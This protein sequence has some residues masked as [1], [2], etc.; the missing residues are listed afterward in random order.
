MTG[1]QAVLKQEA[2]EALVV[3]PNGVFV[4]CTYGRGGHSKM[5]LDRLTPDG[6]LMVIDKDIEAIEHA[7]SKFARDDR[8][9]INHGSF[10]NIG[11]YAD[12]H[13]LG[14]FDGVLIDLGV[15][16]PQ[17]DQ[18]ARGFS[19]DRDGPL[20]MRMDQS[21]GQTTS[22]WLASAESDSRGIPVLF[23]AVTRG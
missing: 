17:L 12:D 20:D 3:N 16:S 1:H 9:F 5:I 6:R 11:Q 4:D 7:T 8:V 10:K 18:A 13:G 19:F 23:P 22:E 21:S 15:S 14:S 2:I